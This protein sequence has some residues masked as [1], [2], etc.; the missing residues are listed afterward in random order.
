MNK[1]IQSKKKIYLEKKARM[2]LGPPHYCPYWRSMRPLRFSRD[3]T[4]PP[5]TFS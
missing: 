2:D 4:L 3:M 1:I 5:L